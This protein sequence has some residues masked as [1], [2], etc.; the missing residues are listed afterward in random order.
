MPVLDH[1]LM[2][3]LKG[4]SAQ[5]GHDAKLFEKLLTAWAKGWNTESAK[6]VRTTMAG[7]KKRHAGGKARHAPVCRCGHMRPSHRPRCTKL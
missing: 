6:R 7:G 1:A 2:D 5:P 4:Y 3:F